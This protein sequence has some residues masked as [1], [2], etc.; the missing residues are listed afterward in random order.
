MQQETILIFNF[1]FWIGYR[2]ISCNM[3]LLNFDLNLKRKF[4][5][6]PKKIYQRLIN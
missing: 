2:I 5:F 4:K 3:I 1:F 6:E